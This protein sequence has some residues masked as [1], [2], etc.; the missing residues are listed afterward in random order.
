MTY[1]ELNHRANQLAH[2]LQRQGVGP[3]VL[4]GVCIE[5][6]LEMLVGILGVLKA[7]GAY[8]PLDPQYPRDRISFMIQDAGLSLILTK[9]HLA[10]DL[11][12]NQV[13][14]LSL[15]EDWER[16]RTKWII[17]RSRKPPSRILSS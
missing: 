15:D 14:L 17:I 1:Y 10:R 13:S 3:E 9:E 8:V 5:R 2:Y 7:G 4:V 16:L 11:P 12:E 6:S